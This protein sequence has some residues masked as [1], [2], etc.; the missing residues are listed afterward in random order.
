MTVA[1]SKVQMEKKALDIKP[2]LIILDIDMPF[3][4]VWDTLASIRFD[5]ELKNSPVI[6]LTANA[7][8]K[9]SIEL[10]P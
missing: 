4:N 1:Y 7:K 9:I 6:M 8:E 5:E 2:D 3:M 10:G